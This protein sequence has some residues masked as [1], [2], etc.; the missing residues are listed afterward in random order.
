[1]NRKRIQTATAAFLGM[2]SLLAGCGEKVVQEAPELLE[3]VSVNEAFRP[4]E[5]GEVG[6][7]KIAL[8]TVKVQEYPH[9]YSTSV[10]VTDILVEIGDYVEVGDI[11]AY[12]D[13]E[14]AKEQL[15]ELKSQLSREQQSFAISEKILELE[16]KQT[17]D[18]TAQKTLK[19]NGSYD[20]KLYEYRV[21]K[22]K[23]QI[24][25]QQE[26]IESGTLVARHSGYVSYIK[27]LAAGNIAGA[28]ENIV[29]VYDPNELYME[30]G[31][32]TTETYEYQDYEIKYLK[33]GNEKI[34]VIEQEYTSQEK[35]LAKASGKSLYIRIQCP[36]EMDFSAG[37]SYPVYFLEKELGE[38]LR[39][40]NDSLFKE[41][42]NTY[43]YVKNTDGK[44]EKREIKIGNQDTYYTQILSG[45]QEGDL[46]FYETDTQLPADYVTCSAARGDFSKENLSKTYQITY[47]ST[48]VHESEHNG[49]ILNMAVEQEQEVEKGQ[50]LYEIQSDTGKAALTE[51][52]KQI[53]RQKESNKNALEEM[54]KLIA[55]S[56]D[57][58]KEILKLQRKQMVLEQEATLEDLTSAYQKLK[59]GNDGTG[60][61]QVYAEESGVITEL[62]VKEGDE[63]SSGQ[64][65]MV[66]RKLN[67]DLILVQMKSI[68]GETVYTDN[69]A[70]L[71]E[72]V[73]IIVNGE[74]ASGSCIGWTC[75]ENDQETGYAYSDENGAH[76]S[77]CVDSGYQFPGFFVRLSEEDQGEDVFKG[78]VTFSYV[79]MKNV[80]L[81]PTSAVYSEENSDDGTKKDYYVWKVEDDELVKQY[82]LVDETY[83]NQ[84]EMVILSGVTEED[85][86]AEAVR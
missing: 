11:L 83:S 57:I 42:Q 12:G 25:L 24:Q 27:N 9:F 78:R 37:D 74:T 15:K 17:T 26:F 32:Y 33:N 79:S 53:E 13:V 52:K 58:Q 72:T 20:K 38:V 44:K 63:V 30:L 76:L 45:L 10:T 65:M 54:D 47:G 70:E 73:T 81:L 29:M 64:T 28:A 1:M 50:L 40:G 85:I 48:Y 6:D 2:V 5:M 31:A 36:A 60:I 68:E 21:Q 80:L 16:L 66:I 43:V 59:E 84:T 19:E 82:V 18:E 61:I 55:E 39:I 46:V 56:V 23:E 22:L 77:Y 62:A 71:G 75:D 7:L 51:A 86:L 14:S 4:V 3:P 8:G 41:G 67:E 49:K 35:I 69:I 34:S